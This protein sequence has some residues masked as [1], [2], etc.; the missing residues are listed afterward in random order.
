MEIEAIDVDDTVAA[1]RE[2]FIRT[3][4]SKIVVYRETLDNVIGYVHSYELFKE[5]SS[6]KS[7]LL[8]ISIIPETIPAHEV[9]EEFTRQSRSIA[10]VVDEFGGTSGIVTM[11]DIIE[12]IFGEIEDEHDTV[13]L[14]EQD[15][16]A[17][18]YLL[19]GRLEID[20]I[21]SRY[22]LSLPEGHDYETLAGYILHHTA[23]I[24]LKG[25][26]LHLG[27]HI[28]EILEV[29]GT[30]IELIKISLPKE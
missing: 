9:L 29:S 2:K 27:N 12:E 30:R 11:E 15:L 18:E 8:P 13:E 24:P 19:S 5:P 3:R 25:T 17:N 4:L 20:Y 1:L 22:P 28:F 6:I 21:N 10:V 26:V 14:I 16:G 23:E 7:M